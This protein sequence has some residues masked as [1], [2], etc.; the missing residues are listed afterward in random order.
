MDDDLKIGLLVAAG[1][2]MGLAR[3]LMLNSQQAE[4][5]AQAI[6]ER[7]QRDMKRVIE[8]RIEQI[9][10]ASSEQAPAALQQGRRR[11]GL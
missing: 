3:F 8:A 6:C 7:R 9:E 2:I 5:V 10:P 11:I 4:T 1:D